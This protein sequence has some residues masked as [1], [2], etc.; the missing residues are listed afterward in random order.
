MP[1]PS[2]SVDALASVVDIRRRLH[3]IPELAFAERE[4]Q[5][6]VRS[7]VGA[8]GPTRAVGGTGL[9]VDLGPADA[10]RALLL[11]ADMD[12]LPVTEATGL[13][14]ASTHPGHMHACGHDAHMAALIVAARRLA[15]DMPPGLRLRLLFQPAEEG[16]GG[17]AACVAD[18][19]LEGID[20]AFGLHVWNELPL[21]T[22]AVPDG[23][24]MAAVAELTVVLRGAGGHA[25]MPAR[26]RNPIPAAATLVG[27]LHA[28]PAQLGSPGDPVVVTVGAVHGGD[29]FN[30][31]PDTVTLR[32]TARA[33]SSS[34]EA[35]VE[36]RV[37]ALAGGI[38]AAHGLQADVRWVRH[39]GATVN[40]PAFAA[41]ARA[42][43]LG[44]SGVR[45][46]RA[47][48]RTTAGEDFGVLLEHVPG[49]FA[50]VGASPPPP[51]APA[52]PHHS[53]RFDVDERVLALAV[54][55]H[56][57]VARRFA[58]GDF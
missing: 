33:M 19:A 28:L 39:C 47:D 21:G 43:A 31:I 38:A 4:T 14:F 10:P 16:A 9:L 54:G 3:R 25:A 18:G 35:R 22:V 27:A 52:A 37:R 44:V 40:A 5:R 13:P 50:L 2:A 24:V 34:T 26:A 32:G 51:A 56:E 58:A 15:A 41:L 45:A 42:V 17:A 23:G 6:L 48:Y 36:A 53:P 12:G 7:L 8:L 49:A 46:V 29:A 55:L 20:A 30:V 57:A 1:D 11:R